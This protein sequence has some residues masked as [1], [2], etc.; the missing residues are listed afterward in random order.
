MLADHLGIE[1]RQAK[2]GAPIADDAHATGE[3]EQK[4]K[5]KRD[6]PLRGHSRDP[7]EILAEQRAVGP[8]GDRPAGDGAVGEVL[9]PH[10]VRGMAA[11]G[12]GE[13]EIDPQRGQA[14]A[15]PRG[16]HRAEE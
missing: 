15:G 2:A 8:R 12:P 7:G 13:V 11:G 10:H 1:R 9:A 16:V 3:E 5:D 14:A 6:D 4:E